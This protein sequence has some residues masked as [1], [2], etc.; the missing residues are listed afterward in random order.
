MRGV[1]K[2]ELYHVLT[3]GIERRKIFL[4]KKDYLRFVHDLFEFNDEQPACSG[5]LRIFRNSQCN[6][7]VR[8]CIEEGEEKQ[9]KE[10][11]KFLVDLLAFTLMQNHY[12]LF[13]SVKNR[14]LLTL[15]MRKLNGGYA[16]YFNERYKRKGPLFES[17]FKSVLVHNEAHFI[18]LP[19]YIHCNPLDFKMP[20]WRKRKIA[21]YQ[22]ALEFLENY[23]WSSH[24]DYIG[25]KN[26]PSVTQR[27][28]LLEYFGGEEG[29]KNDIKTWLENFEGIREK[30]SL[31]E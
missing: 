27:E 1:L 19:Y 6:D 24:A 22:K 25:K 15:F 28:F 8:R 30:F 14:K 11:R 4:D 23:R 16:R 31:E 3:R 5:R 12:H 21:D 17:R 13:I 10:P 18:H 9:Q 26:F 29:Y 20:E 7:V 2:M